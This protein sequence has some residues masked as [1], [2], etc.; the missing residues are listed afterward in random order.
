MAVHC[1]GCCRA[2]PPAP[3]SWLSAGTVGEAWA[4][5]AVRASSSVMGWELGDVKAQALTSAPECS[6]RRCVKM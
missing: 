3:E 6:G 2:G 5:V 4:R 1:R